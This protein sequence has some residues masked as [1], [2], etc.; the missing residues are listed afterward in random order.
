MAATG[1]LPTLHLP[2]F[3]GVQTT[4]AALPAAA[5]T[6]TFGCTIGT[7]TGGGAA[8]Q[9]A[10]LVSEVANNNTKTDTIIY[11]VMM[12]LQQFVGDSFT[13]TVTGLHTRAGGS[14][15]CTIDASVRK[16]TEAGVT[17]ADLCGTAAQELAVG[18]TDTAVFTIDSTNLDAGDR[19]LITITAT[20]VAGDA[21]NNTCNI[22]D[23]KLSD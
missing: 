8:G 1:L 20:I 18:S 2:L 3:Q 5:T 9:S 14:G 21:N 11:D 10:M 16:I 13:L 17:G 6:G 19:F 22:Y 7:V 15:T 12:P 23:I 4:G